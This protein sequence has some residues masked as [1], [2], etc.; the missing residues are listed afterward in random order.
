MVL[1]GVRLSR[2]PWWLPAVEKRDYYYGQE[3]DSFAAPVPDPDGPKALQVEPGH[4]HEGENP[5]S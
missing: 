4:P 5:E 2:A 3:V 1:A